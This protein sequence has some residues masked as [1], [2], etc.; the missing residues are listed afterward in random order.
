[1]IRKIG[2]DGKI[3][4]NKR[5]RE[6]ERKEICMMRAK[7]YNIIYKSRYNF[8]MIKSKPNHFFFVR[9][10]CCTCGPELHHRV[11][12]KEQKQ[13]TTTIYFYTGSSQQRT[14]WIYYATVLDWFD[15]Y[16][17][18]REVSF[19]LRCKIVFRFVREER[20][21]TKKIQKEYENYTVVIIQYVF[22]LNLLT[23]AHTTHHTTSQLN[24]V[25]LK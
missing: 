1:M 22:I 24:V 11:Q 5:E 14:L 4:K 7:G 25:V 18:S 23:Q 17:L 8:I 10:L 15:D 16:P 2:H 19:Y 20:R 21:R 12:T 3:R 9:S 6:R 13:Q